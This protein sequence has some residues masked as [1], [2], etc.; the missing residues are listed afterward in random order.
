MLGN[1]V[2]YV[3]A[4]VYCKGLFMRPLCRRNKDPKLI[5]NL[6]TLSFS[7]QTVVQLQQI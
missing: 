4:F 1:T 3:W 6:A 2:I 7:V 5:N